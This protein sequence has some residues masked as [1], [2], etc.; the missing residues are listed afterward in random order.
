LQL[1]NQLRTPPQTGR[2][3]LDEAEQAVGE[4]D[5]RELEPRPNRQT[6]HLEVWKGEQLSAVSEKFPL[7]FGLWS[8]GYC[9]A[10]ILALGQTSCKLH[11]SDRFDSTDRAAIKLHQQ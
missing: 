4:D 3:R 8:I 7:S 9:I 6:D 5:R 2:I 1:R 11:V 10:L